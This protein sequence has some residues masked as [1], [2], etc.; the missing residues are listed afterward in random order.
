MNIRTSLVEDILTGIH[1]TSLRE[2]P[3]ALLDQLIELVEAR[4]CLDGGQDRDE[5]QVALLAD[6]SERSVRNA[7]SLEG[8]AGLRSKRADAR[9]G[10][11]RTLIEN[12]EAKR[13]LAGRRSFRP[14]KRSWVSETSPSEL[15]SPSSL[16]EFIGLIR[17]R[18]DHLHGNAEAAA[19]AAGV[20]EEFVRDAMNNSLP[21]SDENVEKLAQV[22]Q[23]AGGTATDAARQPTGR[24]GPAQGPRVGKY[25][26]V[27]GA[28]IALALLLGLWFWRSIPSAA[29]AERFPIAC[30]IIA[31]AVLGSAVNEPF[32]ENEPCG[33]SYGWITAYILWKGAV[34]S[35]FAFALYLMAIGGL[36]GGDLFPKFVS[37]AAQG[38]TWNMQQFVTSVDPES[39]KDVAKI[40]VWSFIAGYSEKLVPN[41]IG[42]RLKGAEN[43]GKP[44]G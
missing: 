10:E 30:F 7:L 6:M 12:Q 2:N 34:S 8:P 11:K 22:L 31:A 38:T 42:K 14:T 27:A 16:R 26:A 37:T 5:P 33:A 41:L 21:I 32:R 44:G 13:W 9:D 24:P 17:Q 4:A 18:I 39:Y 25:G 15:P 43:E 35:V 23:G 36:I 1:F 3:A 19:A 28:L 20:A 29:G 40:L